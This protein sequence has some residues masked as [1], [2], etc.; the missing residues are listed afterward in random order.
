MAETLTEQVEQRISTV[1]DR[2]TDALAELAG[3]WLQTDAVEASA[4]ALRTLRNPI[5]I[6]ANKGTTAV[7]T[8]GAPGAAGWPG[9]IK[10]GDELMHGIAEIRGLATSET[11][12]AIKATAAD[13]ERD[14]EAVARKAQRVARA[15]AATVGGAA[16]D[17]V[18]P[19]AK[20]LT[21]PLIVVGL[22]AVAAV[23]WKVRS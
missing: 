5:E 15:T 3:R 1:R 18:A 10:A 22:V 16:G 23:V 7:E 2:H 12:G 14:A 9:W 4:N 6:W 8:G 19:A 11:L 17:L 21:I 20:A 13:V